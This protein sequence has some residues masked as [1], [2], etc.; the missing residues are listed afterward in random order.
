MKS[1]VE[2][3]S[4]TRVKLTVEV[5][6]EELKPLLDKAYATIG[7]QVQ[8]PGFRR[9]KVPS[10][11]IDQRVGR[12]AVVQEAVNEALPIFFAEAV[13]AEEV[14]AI[15]AP[16][17]DITAV[18]L[19]DGQDLEF[20]VETDVRPTIELPD[21]NGIA[22]T[23]DDVAV[24]DDDVEQRMTS[25]R[26]RFGTL[27]GVDRAVE[28]GDHVSLDLSATI[29]GEE[30]DS[31]ENVSY[32]VG[33]G[34]MLEGLD[35]AL[36]GMTAGETKSFTAPLA[37]GDREGQDADCVVTVQSVKVRE[38]PELDDDFAQLASQFDTLDEL[39]ADVVSQTEQAKKYEQG[40][41]ARDKVLE[42]LLDTVDVPVPDGIVKAEVDSHLEGENRMDD[43][44]HRAE[45]D[46]STRRALKAQFLLDAIAEKLEVKV[47]QPELIEYLVM[48][49]QQYG[50]D[51]NQFAQAIDQQGQIPSMVQEVARRKALAA[52]LDEAVVT[53]S[54]GTVID[55]DELVQGSDEDDD[56]VESA[57]VTDE[58]S[59][60]D[61]APVED[62]TPAK[63]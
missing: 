53:D 26:E 38:L 20:T 52:V 18:P 57:E 6:F 48:S 61:D 42:H 43:D 15:G 29:D 49:A 44:E 33:S 39:R 23:V 59:P 58:A 25:L 12:G 9:G 19:E 34:N 47:E 22:V 60:S 50:M 35:D 13:E 16:E 27:V 45:V 3:L 2:T 4:P 63:A 24:S 46:E 17:V 51:P 5:P 32:E 37:G 8:V 14:R 21:L 7:S 30:I 36:V 10:R 54:S 31:V 40:I 62:E 11:I 55:L 28:T 41:Q 1:A 56:Q